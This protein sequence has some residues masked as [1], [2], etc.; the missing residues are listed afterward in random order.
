MEKAERKSAF[1]KA[2]NR[3]RDIIYFLDSKKYQSE[4]LNMLRQILKENVK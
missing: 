3:A 2:V 4:E 1:E